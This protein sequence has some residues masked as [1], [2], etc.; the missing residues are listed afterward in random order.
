MFVFHS[1]WFLLFLL[2]L[3]MPFFI[4]QKN[5]GKISFPTLS[6]INRVRTSKITDPDFILKVLKV[7]SLLFLIIAL[8]RPQSGRKF[9]EIDSEGVDILLLLDT[10][11]SMKAL[12]FKEKDEPV[13]RLYIVKKVVADFIKQRAGDRLGLIVFGDEA[14]TQCPLTTDH[15]IVLTLLKQVEIGMVGESTNMGT[16]IGVG[17][18]RIKDIVF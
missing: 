9:T 6:V 12:D 17:I 5:R 16:S 7:L 8:A 15:D 2:A 4:K 13:D 10:S 14:F 3:P 18:N 1:P 11:G